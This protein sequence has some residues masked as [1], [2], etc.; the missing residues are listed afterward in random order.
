MTTITSPEL[1]LFNAVFSYA[2]S[3][4]CERVYDTPPDKQEV[5]PFVTL[6]TEQTTSTENKSNTAKRLFLTVHIWAT[7]DQRQEL[8]LIRA[9]LVN[10][11]KIRAA[12]WSFIARPDEE[13]SDTITDTTV[14]NS[15]FLHG[16]VTLVYDAYNL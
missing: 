9:K 11:T 10:L 14:P 3:R 12:G 2:Q 15:T 4:V 13:T 16:T 7:T 8:E 6:G 1:A 5:C